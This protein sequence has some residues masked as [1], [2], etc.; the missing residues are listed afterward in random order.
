[1][2]DAL[3]LDPAGD[4]RI[5]ALLRSLPECGIPVGAQDY[6]RLARV[7]ALPRTWERA[8]LCE[9]LVALL[10]VDAR[11]R[12]LVRAQFHRLLP[13][14]PEAT[15]GP[16]AGDDTDEAGDPDQ[17]GAPQARPG[18]PPTAPGVH[19]PQA[20]AQP[21]GGGARRR[22]LVRTVARGIALPALLATALLLT[23][24]APRTPVPGAAGPVTLPE[25]APVTAPTS[26]PAPPPAT[27][28]V[29]DTATGRPLLPA[30]LLSLVSA[31]GLLVLYT[32]WRGP[33]LTRTASIRPD[34]PRDFHWSRAQREMPR[35]LDYRARRDMVWGVQRFDGRPDRARL[36]IRR[37]VTASARRAVPTPRFAPARREREVWLWLDRQLSS[38]TAHALADQVESDLRR[39]GLTVRRAAFSVLPDQVLFDNGERA[40]VPDLDS[41]AGQALVAVF[42][43][44]NLLR[45]EWVDQGFERNAAHRLRPLR[46]WPRLRL[47]DFADDATV[48]DFARRHRL[49]RITPGQLPA[50]LA[51]RPLGRL[52]R[53]QEPLLAP[54]QETLWRAGCALV[55]EPPPTRGQALALYQALG[56]PR[57][58]RVP[59]PRTRL[60]DDAELLRFADDE[61]TTLLRTLAD[62][63]WEDIERE[64]GQ[65]RRPLLAALAFWDQALDAA[66]QALARASAASGALDPALA[67]WSRS[68]GRRRLQAERALLQLWHGGPTADAAAATLHGLERSAHAAR[69]HP[70]AAELADG[71]RG[72]LGRLGARGI[73]GAG[74]DTDTGR[75]NLPWPWRDQGHPLTITEDT[76]RRLRALGFAGISPRATPRLRTVFAAAVLVGVCA[77]ALRAMLDA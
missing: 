37:T 14:T 65:A 75:I 22:A 6:A 48:A 10:A 68:I 3:R 40:T 64:R 4:A 16:E 63:A 15:D 23:R 33:R 32:H 70:A 28:A 52:P 73:A 35:L 62:W 45:R 20:P 7:F 53:V 57:R 71:I 60:H 19:E 31:G 17:P 74:T 18:H 46:D 8:E 67:D 50:W 24:S 76:R 54:H 43:D 36:H 12:T 69:P 66:D 9:L 44:G 41:D 27:A 56:L 49:Q 72:R 47:V 58:V 51:E 39:A 34:G 30:L 59:D 1:M 25:P 61:R 11:E 38:R 55:Q 13:A 5:G 42:M 29:T 2:P 26:A 21:H 77:A